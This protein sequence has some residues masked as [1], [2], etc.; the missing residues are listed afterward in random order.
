MKQI[1]L[2]DVAKA[3]GVSIGTASRA[4]NN[5]SRVSASA[6][7][8]VLDAAREL[9]YLRPVRRTRVIA[10]LAP[11]FEIRMLSDYFLLMFNAFRSEIHDRGYRA[12][13]LSREDFP[14][15]NEWPVDGAVSLDYI[16][17]ISR[18]FPRTSNIP[19]V[20]CNDR[21]NHLENIYT[22]RSNSRKVLREVVEL[23]AGFGH[24]RIGLTHFQESRGQADKPDYGGFFREAMTAHGLGGG[25][26]YRPYTSALPMHEAVAMLLRE[27]I[28]AL[29]AVDHSIEADRLLKLSGRRIPEDISLVAG[30]T[31]AAV[32]MFP[33]HTTMAIDYP[34]VARTAVDVLET[35]WNGGT[36]R[37]DIFIDSRLNIR[38]STGPAPE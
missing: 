10:I 38:E 30:D 15:L 14:L 26:F 11:T 3:A 9:G 27:G 16:G 33:R 29:I 24:L 22:I 2:S 20:C 28:T 31:I 34:A 17:E 36:I 4:M 37:Q 1:T 19:L 6:R 13:T 21:P 8:S 12:V 23:L 25:A 5:R 18:Q 32:R 35:V 7:R